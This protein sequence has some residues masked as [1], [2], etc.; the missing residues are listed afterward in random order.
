MSWSTVVLE[1]VKVNGRRRESRVCGRR[2]TPTHARNGRRVHDERL[3][4]RFRSPAADSGRMTP[5]QVGRT[6]DRRPSRGRPRFATGTRSPGRTTRTHGRASA[7]PPT[8]RPATARPMP[9]PATQRTDPG[10]P[11][12]KSIHTRQHLIEVRGI[13]PRRHDVDF[14]SAHGRAL[15]VLPVEEIDQQWQLCEWTRRTHAAASSPCRVHTV[16]S[17]LHVA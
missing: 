9:R 16:E 5:C 11:E 14:E 15:H 13:F 10:R 4:P 8:A 7:P 3:G 17:D 12:R 6:R 2:R 1:I